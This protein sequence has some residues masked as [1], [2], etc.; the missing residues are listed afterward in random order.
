MLTAEHSMWIAVR[1]F[2]GMSVKRT[3]FAADKTDPGAYNLPL[4]LAFADVM[5]CP[6]LILSPKMSKGFRF[7]IMDVEHTGSDRI[8]IK[9]SHDRVKDNLNPHALQVL[10]L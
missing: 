5:H 4:Y 3:V 9:L 6:G 7:V 8:N 10:D 2:G 1:A